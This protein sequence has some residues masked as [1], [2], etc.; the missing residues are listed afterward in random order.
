MHTADI[1]RSSIPVARSPW[2]DGAFQLLFAAAAASQTCAQIG[3]LAVPLVAVIALR[4]GPG[5]VGLLA[6]L[7]TAAFL[8]IGLPAGAWLDRL[9]RRRVMITAD[10]VRALLLASVPVAWLLDR[11][12]M[13]QLYAVV[14]LTG[15]ATVFFDVAA[16]SHLPDLVGRRALTDAN[17]SLVSLQAAGNVAGRGVGGYLVQWLTAPLAV[18]AQAVGYLLSAGLLTRI[19][20]PDT[21]PTCD[22]GGR[23][24]LA[25]IRRG[26]THVLGDAELRALALSGACAN[27][28]TQL[29]NTVLPLLFVREPGLSPAALGL[30]W[31]VGGVGVFVGARLARPVARRIGVGR[32]LGAASLAVAPAG[33]L[34]PA[35]GPGPWLWVAGAGWFLSTCKAGVGNVLGVTLRQQS[36]P[37]PMLGRMNATFRFLLTGALAVGSLV[38]AV[39]GEFWGVR[40]ALWAGGGL[41]A[42]AWLPVVLSPLRTRREMPAEA[43]AGG[44]RSR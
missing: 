19:R 16:Q 4:A 2:R 3:Y 7:S 36:T 5:Q 33:L 27:C 14:L 41:L 25:E 1:S 28:G 35:A 10:L 15:C 34:I 29:V 17:A 24:L 12:T 20:R 32:T 26:L 44:G 22:P 42:V 38:A 30:F 13:Q 37:D 18:A 8:L 39:V 40:A 9:R 11:L 31:S 23:R 43:A 21:S 6:A